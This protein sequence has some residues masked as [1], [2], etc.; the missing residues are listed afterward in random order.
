VRRLLLLLLSLATLAALLF[1]WGYLNARAD[2]V[3]RRAHI[4]LLGWPAGATPVRVVLMSDVHIGSSAMDADRLSRIVGQVNALSPD[5]ILFAGDFVFRHDP[6]AAGKSA[7]ELTAPLTGLHAP[8]GVIATLGNHDQ[9]TSPG[10][11]RAAVRRAGVTVLEN[12]AVTRGPLAI[13]GVGDL[14]SGHAELT[15]VLRATK[16]LHGAPVMVT[17]SPDLAPMLPPDIPLLLAGHTIADRSFCRCG[18]R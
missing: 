13:G 14:F 5:L 4:G 3:V 10:Q 18:G 7:E 11:I 6:V 2:P 1:G 8:L 12:Q 16:R 15:A 9:W 17:H